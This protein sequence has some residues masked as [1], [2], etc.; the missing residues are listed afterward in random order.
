MWLPTSWQ[1]WVFTTRSMSPKS[2][3][4]RDVYV[5]PPMW[6]GSLRC[7]HE[8]LAMSLGWFC[9]IWH[10]APASETAAGVV[11][12]RYIW[13]L[14]SFWQTRSSPLSISDLDNGPTER[15]AVLSPERFYHS[16]CP[17]VFVMLNTK[18]YFIAVTWDK[19]L[20]GFGIK[21]AELS[22]PSLFLIQNN[23][24]SHITTPSLSLPGTQ[25]DRRFTEMVDVNPL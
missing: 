20:V 4:L 8:K 24:S 14:S 13:Y 12:P 1:I 15:V 6:L 5:P 25:D 2:I 19:Q 7:A 21:G 18:Q 10:R 3:T 17:K 9:Y 22:C 23:P 16:F 11:L